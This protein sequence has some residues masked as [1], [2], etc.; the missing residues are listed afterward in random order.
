MAQQTVLVV[1][2][3]GFLGRHVL[4]C[5]SAAGHRAIG[6]CR[7][8]GAPPAVPRVSW[9]ATDLGREDATRNWPAH[10]DTLIYL[11]QARSWRHFPATAPETYQ[12]NVAG[13][14]RAAWHAEKIGVTRF[15]YASTGSVYTRKTKPAKED[16]GID[17][18]EPRTFYASCKLAGELLLGPYQALFPVVHLR[19]F[20]PYG[21]GQSE[22]MLMPRLVR[23]V[24]EGKPIQLHG[25]D[26]LVA[27][28]V[29]AMDVAETIVRCL[30]LTH[31]ATLNVAG[32]ETLTLRLIGEQIGKVVQRAPVFEIQAD[33]APAVIA[34][35]TTLL[36]RTL[37]W[38]PAIPLDE[39]L[40][41][42]LADDTCRLA[43]PA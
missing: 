26:G 25:E 41:A 16:D 18:G 19:I 32:P 24:R 11:A 15:I 1:G 5:V 10:Y 42:W 40:R 33:H 27:N 30:E 3:A 14:M 2:G 36:R 31:T 23:C 20:M 29:A 22:D 9:I 43:V 8:A 7:G 28:P 38:Q 17:L 13:L 35:D 21:D 37:D 12:V 4:R 6:T 34:G 39:G